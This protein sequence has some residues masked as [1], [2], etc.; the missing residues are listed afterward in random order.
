MSSERSNCC[1]NAA[2]VDEIDLRTWKDSATF[3][4]VTGAVPPEH[5]NG[6]GLP[7]TGGAMGHGP[8]H[9]YLALAAGGNSS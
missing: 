3:L 5:W 4:G 9:R 8:P 6:T 1:G 7:L 2:F